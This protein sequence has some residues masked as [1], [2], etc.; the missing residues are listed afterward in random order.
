MFLIIGN[1]FTKETLI[2]MFRSGLLRKF[3]YTFFHRTPPVATSV[4]A[5]YIPS[6]K[7]AHDIDFYLVTRDLDSQLITCRFCITRIYFTQ[8]PTLSLHLLVT[9][10]SNVTH[11]S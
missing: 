5:L 4:C 7:C 1:L 9:Q 10:I 2:K 11:N 8:L 3:K 6:V